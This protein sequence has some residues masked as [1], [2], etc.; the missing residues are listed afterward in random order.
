MGTFG[1][2][3]FKLILVIL[4][5][6]DTVVGFEQQIY[7]METVETILS[8]SV[9]EVDHTVSDNQLKGIED[10]TA[11]DAFA[12]LVKEKMSI[13]REYQSLEKELKNTQ[14]KADV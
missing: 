8:H 10:A 13:E 6:F 12:N 3:L 5:I 2:E 14:G 4:N 9:L 7:S 1:H 11:K